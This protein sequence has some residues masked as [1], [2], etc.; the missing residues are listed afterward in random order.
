MGLCTGTCRGYSSR[1]S[2]SRPA[3]CGAGRVVEFSFLTDTSKRSGAPRRDAKRRGVQSAAAMRFSRSRRACTAGGTQPHHRCPITA[4]RIVKYLLTG[5]Q[6]VKPDIPLRILS[7]HSRLDGAD[8]AYHSV[9]LRICFPHVFAPRLLRPS[10]QNGIAARCF[11]SSLSRPPL[12]TLLLSFFSC[13]EAG[14]WT[15]VSGHS[16]GPVCPGGHRA[17]ATKI[18]ENL[19]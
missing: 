18:V 8:Q 2:L 15:E 14:G 13:E 3:R 1:W 16:V 11:L 9:K 4:L 7:W 17:R 12:S 5:S 6:C 10:K 19:G